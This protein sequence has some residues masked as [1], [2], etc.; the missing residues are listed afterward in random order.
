MEHAF[1]P[2]KYGVHPLVSVA[3]DCEPVFA[4]APPHPTGPATSSCCAAGPGP[5]NHAAP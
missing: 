3:V 1:D 2:E 5:W 4:H